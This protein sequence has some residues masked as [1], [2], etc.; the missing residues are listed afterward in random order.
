MDIP[1]LTV[2]QMKEVDQLMIKA[3]ITVPRMM[4]LAGYVTARAAVDIFKPRKALILVGKG[5]NGGDGLSAARHLHNMGVE[6]CIVLAGELHKEDSLMQLK[7]LEELGIKP[8]PNPSKLGKPDLVIDA[9][10][11]YSAKGEPRGGVALLVREAKLL[12]KP[13]LSIDI[14]TGLEATSGKWFDPAF[15]G[16]TCLALSLP[17]KGMDKDKKIARLY[18]GDLGV[19]REILKKVGVEAPVMFR[20]GMYGEVK[21]KL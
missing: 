10:L 19:P 4:E 9:L 14:P 1:T 15:E 18:V 16:A 3:G 17:K 20:E 8:L 13:I 11:G 21:R 5:N 7:P 6:V 2:E 12:G